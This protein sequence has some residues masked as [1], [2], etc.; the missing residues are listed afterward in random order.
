MKFLPFILIFALA[1]CSQPENPATQLSH[2]I[3]E[4][5]PAGTPLASARQIMEQHQFA[6]TVSSYD[7]KSAMPSGSDTIRWDTGIIRDGKPAALTNLS[8]MT[9]SRTE[10]NGSVLVYEATLTVLN[11]ETDSKLTVSSRRIR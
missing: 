2:Q 3:Q 9:C 5:V 4:W 10:T 7:S 8:L 11:G 6:C 1:G